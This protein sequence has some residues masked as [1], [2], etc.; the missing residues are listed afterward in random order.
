MTR[1][2][3]V[4]LGMVYP[5]Y[6]SYKSVKTHNPSALEEW[7]KYWLVISVMALLSLI[8]DPILY[9]RV[10]M[11]SLIRIAVVAYLVLPMTK[12]YKQIY[13]VVLH[14]QLAKHENTIDQAADQFAKAADDTIK[15]AGPKV[16]EIM[17][18]GKAMATQA[19][20]KGKKM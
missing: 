12:G 18:K 11:Y 6:K 5:G 3:I 8:V 4:G 10:P 7:L 20:N 9:G 15:N 17:A 16:N 19:A 13:E 14:P 1:V 2:C